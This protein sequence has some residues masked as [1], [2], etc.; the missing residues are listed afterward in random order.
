MGLA[1]A[2][3]VRSLR[4]VSSVRARKRNSRQP[5]QFEDKYAVDT[6]PPHLELADVNIIW[7]H[8]FV[9][10]AID[11]H[12]L[13]GAIHKL[14]DAV[15]GGARD[16]YRICGCRRPVSRSR[17]CATSSRFVRFTKWPKH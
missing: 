8:L 15:A 6:Y 10:E 11:K 13:L 3:F 2:A 1:I 14:A 7:G 5:G 17:A 9:V 16:R 4:T 12:S